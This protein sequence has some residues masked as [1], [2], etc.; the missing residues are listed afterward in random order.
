MTWLEDRVLG[1]KK[2]FTLMV[3]RTKH[4]EETVYTVD[5]KAKDP[6]ELDSR[7]NELDE[8]GMR[9]CLQ[10]EEGKWYFEYRICAVHKK[11]IGRIISEKIR[12]NKN[13]QNT[14]SS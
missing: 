10:D 8:E 12:G 7:M 3:A 14:L 1:K 11:A 4:D 2:I 5:S 6:S 13:V 9:W